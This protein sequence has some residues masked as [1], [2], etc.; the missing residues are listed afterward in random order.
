MDFKKPVLKNK[1][2][3]RFI[4]AILLQKKVL[5]LCFQT[6]IPDPPYHSYIEGD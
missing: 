6:K 4:H 5:N 3:I 1:H 2:R